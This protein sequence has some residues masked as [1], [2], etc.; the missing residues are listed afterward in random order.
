MVKRIHVPD[1]I[2]NFVV[3][4]CTLLP[5]PA[6]ASSLSLGIAAGLTG[7]GFQ[8]VYMPTA[9]GKPGAGAA[10]DGGDPCRL[11]PDRP[12]QLLRQALQERLGGEAGVAPRYDLAV[13]YSIGRR[14]HRDPPRHD[15]DAHSAD[16]H[17]NWT[18]TAPSPAH[19]A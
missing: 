6:V 10:G 18:L 7:C 2:V 12:G 17:A 14:G 3:A 9:S 11:I 19:A 13:G 8:P 16:R 4:G 15:A 5:P 1:R